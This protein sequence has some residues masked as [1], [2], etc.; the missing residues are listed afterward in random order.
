ME[1]VVVRVQ[2]KGEGGKWRWRVIFTYLWP[3]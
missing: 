3:L 2:V 1:R